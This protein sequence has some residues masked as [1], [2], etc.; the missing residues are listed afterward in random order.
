M[1]HSVILKPYLKPHESNTINSRLSGFDN[2]FNVS[3]VVTLP[4]G[5]VETRF[6][7]RDEI[8]GNKKKKKIIPLHISLNQIF[9]M[10]GWCF[11]WC[12]NQS[13]SV[14]ILCCDGFRSISRLTRA[15]SVNPVIA[16]V[17]LSTKYSQSPTGI[18]TCSHYL[19]WLCQLPCQ[20]KNVQEKNNDTY[21]TYTR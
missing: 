9:T 1:Q 10:V 3:F 21:E 16:L 4:P 19:L 12:I 6:R 15:L 11:L 14:W 20:R 2:D 18:A 17:V 13:E 5:R 7:F 8:T